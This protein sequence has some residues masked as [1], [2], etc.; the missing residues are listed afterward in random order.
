MHDSLRDALRNAVRRLLPQAAQR[1]QPQPHFV[2]QR[3][4]RGWNGSYPALPHLPIWWAVGIDLESE[5]RG[6]DEA[7]AMHHADHL[8][9]VGTAVT[10]QRRIDG[11][12]LVGECVQ[13]VL[14]PPYAP[15]I[16]D[17]VEAA[18]NRVA[19]LIDE[20]II[21]LR[22]VAPVVNFSSDSTE[23]IEF[24]DQIT[25]RPL[26]DDEL[27]RLY[28][29]DLYRIHATPFWTPMNLAMWAFTGT[30]RPRKLLGQANS[31]DATIHADLRESLSRAVLALRT[32]KAGAVGYQGIRLTTERALP[33]IA[34]VAMGGGEYVPFSPYELPAADV[35][36][37]T[38]HVKRLQRELHPALSA[39]CSHLSS[40]S[41]RTNPRDMII[42]AVVGLESIVLAHIEDRGE[43]SFRFALNYAFLDDDRTVRRAAFRDARVL[44]RLRSTIAHG[45]TPSEPI[46]LGGGDHTVSTAAQTA[47]EMLRRLVSRL[48]DEPRFPPTQPGFWEGRYF[49]SAWRSAP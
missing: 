3:N 6:V 18:I 27:T 22:F 40:A 23:A 36:R 9:L 21:E 25:L 15:T 38:A 48:L 16:G 39:A 31:H 49:E 4:E 17:P 20:P 13:L 8:E 42:D 41:I 5:S 1:M 24:S 32:F 2:I 28:G 26:S 14:D 19:A 34:T 35:P 11:P 7:L 30:I 10:G 12:S 33:W 45:D 44:Y 46:S 29:G 43:M 47:T 37:F